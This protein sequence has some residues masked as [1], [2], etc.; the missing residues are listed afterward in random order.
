MHMSGTINFRSLIRENK[1]TFIVIGIVI[2]LL[3]VQIFAVFAMKSGRITRMQILDQS[4]EVVHET[5]GKNLSDFNRY[6]FEKNFG[7]LENYKVRNVTKEV[8]FPFRAWFV[9]AVG[10]PVGVILLFGF[11]VRAYMALF[12]EES[13]KKDRFRSRKSKE[14][15]SSDDQ[16]LQTDLN[17]AY[18]DRTQLEKLLDRV[19]GFNIFVIGF[20]VFLAVFSYWVIPNSISYIMKTGL[21]MVVRFKWFF[22]SAAFIFTGVFVWIVYLKYLL[23]KKTI[24]TRAEVEK[25]R[26]ELEY[27]YKQSDEKLI[28]YK[29]PEKVT[30]PEIT[31]DN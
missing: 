30:K 17:T 8:P 11:V 28:E 25:K 21:D 31:W 5:D 27:M 26:L 12:Y 14:D 4:G 2:I 3:E 10:I 24:E 13:R 23:A 7:P 15:N 19:S 20:L 16:T 18:D 22:L 29:E 6:Y 9:S 1:M